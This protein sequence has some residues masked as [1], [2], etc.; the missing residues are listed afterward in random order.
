[1]SVANISILML[2]GEE[3]Y[4]TQQPLTLTLGEL[5][6]EIFDNKKKFYIQYTL[7]FKNK[8]LAVKDSKKTLKHHGFKYGSNLLQIVIHDERQAEYIT[9][10]DEDG[11][12]RSTLNIIDTNMDIFTLY[13][14]METKKLNSDGLWF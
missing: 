4:N 10:I 6:S 12:K 2:S 13:K 8:K 5:F 14:N 9:K 7:L 1:M 11:G 3:F